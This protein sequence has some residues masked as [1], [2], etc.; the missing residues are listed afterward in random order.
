[1]PMD[2]TKA[3]LLADMCVLYWEYDTKPDFTDENLADNSPEKLVLG[4]YESLKQEV[5]QSYPWRSAIKYTTLTTS[6]PN[7]IPDKKYG[8]SV[9]VPTDFLKEDGFWYDETR[10]MAITQGIEVVGKT[11]RT[12]LESF[13]M[14]YIS[15]DTLESNMDTWLISYLQVYIAAKA[16]DIG[17]LSA[18][19]KN[20]L[21]QQADNDFWN[22][23][24]T[25]WKMAHKDN[26]SLNDSI[27]QFVIS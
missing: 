2:A 8:R 27:N 3:K 1:M 23:S 7:P 15:K 16:A 17:G 20:L 12:N 14:G 25:D 19:R 5:L 26:D 6:V 21:L 24:N 10:H 18:D 22:Y 9:A 13:T 4:V 11:V